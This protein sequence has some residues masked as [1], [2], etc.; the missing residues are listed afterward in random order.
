MLSVYCVQGS[1]Q[2]I[3]LNTVLFLGNHGIV[4][5]KQE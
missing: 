5:D 4:G 2:L 1:Q 3:I